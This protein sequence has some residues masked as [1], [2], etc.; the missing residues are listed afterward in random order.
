LAFYDA[1][2]SAANACAS[3]RD[4]RARALHVRI[5]RDKSKTL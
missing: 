5:P 2:I 1:E 3:F 4:A